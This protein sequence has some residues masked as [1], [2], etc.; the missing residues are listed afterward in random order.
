MPEEIMSQ[1][2]IDAL[3]ARMAAGDN[4]SDTADGAA[5]AEPEDDEA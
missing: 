1:S 4:A 3:I 2:D 5:D